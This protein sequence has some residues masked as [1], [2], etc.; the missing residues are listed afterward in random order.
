MG[1]R[2]F[3]LLTARRPSQIVVMRSSPKA[4]LTLRYIYH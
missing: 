3:V 2:A 1:Q 4:V